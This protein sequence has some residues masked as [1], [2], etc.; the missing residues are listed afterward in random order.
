MSCVRGGEGGVDVD[1]PAIFD[2]NSTLGSL[3][4]FSVK[5]NGNSL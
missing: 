3:I 1:M 4:D 5:T 2:V